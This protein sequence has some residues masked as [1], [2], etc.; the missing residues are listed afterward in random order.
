[1]MAFFVVFSHSAISSTTSLCRVNSVNPQYYP[2]V[3]QD[4]IINI[5]SISLLPGHWINPY[6]GGYSTILFRSGI[7]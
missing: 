5:N 3:K 6:A 4:S 1:F 7:T 2:G